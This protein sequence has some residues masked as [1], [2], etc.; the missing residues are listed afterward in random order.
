MALRLN[1]IISFG[2][3]KDEELEDVLED[4]PQ[5]L[6][7]MYSNGFELDVEVIRKMEDKKLI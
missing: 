5:Y 6:V 1:S 3:Y 7:W 4:D 2:K